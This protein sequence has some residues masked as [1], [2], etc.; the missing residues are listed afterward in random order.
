MSGY[1]NEVTLIGNLRA[2]PEIR[3]THDG[4]PIASLRLATTE[5]WRD[6]NTGEKGEKTEWHSALVF[7]EKLCKVIEQ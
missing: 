3:R 6:R 5:S 4:R 2:D 7:N 1:L